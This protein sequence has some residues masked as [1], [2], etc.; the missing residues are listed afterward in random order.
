MADSKHTPEII[1]AALDPD[2]R[3][4]YR[5]LISLFVDNKVLNT[6]QQAKYDGYKDKIE[7][8]IKKQSAPEASDKEPGPSNSDE[9]GIPSNLRVKR[10]YTMSPEALA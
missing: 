9:P 4:Q 1:N 2:E 7:T 10:R 5:S 6:Q 3:I 8:Y